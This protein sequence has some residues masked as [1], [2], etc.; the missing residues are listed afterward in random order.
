[1][2][3]TR[4]LKHGSVFDNSA[5]KKITRS[6]AAFL[7][8][9]VISFPLVSCMKQ[10]P[11]SK[12][13]SAEEAR[14]DSLL[15]KK[16]REGQAVSFRDQK[17][18]DGCD[19]SAIGL[20]LH[21]DEVPKRSICDDGHVFVL[22]N[23][24]RLLT[25]FLDNKSHGAMEGEDGTVIRSAHVSSIDISRFLGLQEP[26]WSCSMEAVC[27]FL[28]SENGDGKLLVVPASKESGVEFGSYRIGEDVSGASI[29][30]HGGFTFISPV[31][32]GPGREA[33]MM[34]LGL[35]GGHLNG[36]ASMI[37]SPEEWFSRS[38]EKPGKDGTSAGSR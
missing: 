37:M 25:V 9:S 29:R 38:A 18:K 7:A 30:C 8:S 20:L 19:E 6:A 21:K 5:G 15:Q 12:S 17:A 32:N 24:G 23:R 11:G 27:Y 10:C 34:V 26:K 13:P 14:I 36:V 22:T 33:T 1:M 2:A 31:F 3:L 16:V 4:N 35:D 28:I